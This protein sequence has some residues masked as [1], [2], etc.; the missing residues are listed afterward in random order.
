MAHQDRERG[1]ALGTR[2]E[3]ETRDLR[4]CT[5]DAGAP[6]RQPTYI[7]H[8]S[9]IRFSGRLFAP[10]PRV[11]QEMLA[12]DHINFLLFLQ[13]QVKEVLGFLQKGFPYVRRDRCVFEIE[14]SN[15][16]QGLSQLG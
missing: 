7:E 2:Y 3:V 15:N 13:G 11:A 14:E 16:D 8:L 12:I 4:E 10:Q 6:A 1:A 9:I 5:D